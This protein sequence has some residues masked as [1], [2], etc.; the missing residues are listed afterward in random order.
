MTSAGDIPDLEDVHRVEENWKAYRNII[1]GGFFFND[2]V[3]ALADYSDDEKVN[4]ITKDVNEYTQTKTADNLEE[5]EH[6]SD[7]LDDEKIKRKSVKVRNN[8]LAK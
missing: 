6:F 8:L 3:I 1:R 4:A 2:S 5:T 7:F